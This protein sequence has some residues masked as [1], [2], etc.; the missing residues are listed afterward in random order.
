MTPPDDHK[1][2]MPIDSD[3]ALRIQSLLADADLADE[4]ALEELLVTL[5]S[6]G[7]GSPPAASAELEGFLGRSKG[8][9]VRPLRGGRGRR[10]IIAGSLGLVGFLGI[11]TSAA[12]LTGHV[13]DLPEVVRNLPVVA[14]VAEV[15]A[16]AGLDPA[17]LHQESRPTVT[18]N[19]AGD[20]PSQGP[21]HDSGAS[22]GTSSDGSPA[23][24]ATS[25]AGG[26][27]TTGAPTPL[28]GPDSSGRPDTTVTDNPRSQP[29]ST[30]STPGSP[31]TAPQGKANGA[32]NGNG[33]G[34]NGKG[35]GPASG[36][37]QGNQGNPQRGT[38]TTT[39]TTADAPPAAN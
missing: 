3:R 16:N 32:T 2:D 5:A 1:D 6:V 17:P 29:S 22:P 24:A 10:G 26:Q 33:P 37:T 4:A 7:E 21:T 25:S 14:A 9:N 39:G 35:T 34:T 36:A 13:G 19:E 11:S 15:L 31:S 27:G 28:G 18:R 38:A 12:A 30:P 23:G 20:G 8:S